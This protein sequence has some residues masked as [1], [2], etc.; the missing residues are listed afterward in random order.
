MIC[1]AATF[2]ETHFKTGKNRTE[3]SI[4]EILSCNF[5][6]IVRRPQLRRDLPVGFVW[7]EKDGEVCFHPDESVRAAISNVF[8][9][10]AELCSARRVWLRLRSEGLSFPLDTLRCRDRLGRPKLH[11]DLSYI[12]ES[13]VRRGLR[14]WEEPL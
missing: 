3:E 13:G 4:I 1:L 10:F 7:G 8:A 2:V 6:Q 11:R 14:L 5:L 12:D 9:R